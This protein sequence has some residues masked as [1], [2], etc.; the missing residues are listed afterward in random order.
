MMPSRIISAD[1]HMIEPPDLWTTR[2]DKKLRD[3]APHVEVSEKGSYFVAPGLKPSPVSLGFG[4]GRSGQELKEHFKKGYET[5]PAGGWD[6]VE[7]IKDQDIDGVIAEV[8]YTTYGM[9]LFSLPDPELQLA[10]FRAYNDWLAEFCAHNPR[11]FSGIGLISL[12][13]I[14]EGVKELERCAQI[15]LRGAQ[16]WGAPPADRPYWMRVWDPL[17]SAGQELAMPLSLH[18]GTGKRDRKA[19]KAPTADPQTGN[20]GPFMTGNYVNMVHELQRS[21]TDIIFGGVLER[22]PRLTL[23]SAENDSGWV[24]HYMYRMDHAFE[25][26]NAMSD[27]PLPQKPS[28]YIRRQMMATFQDDPIGPMTHEF[29]GADNYMWASDFPHTDCTWPYSRKVIERDFAKLPDAVTHKIV[30]ENVAR[31]YHMEV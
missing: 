12:E 18:I 1:S 3:Q 20:R 2:L 24:P 16:V 7:R 5:A 11:R 17:W 21:F 6:P 15:G 29:F 13:D 4:A 9:P 25:K 26:F 23:I 19:V 27:E 14:G 22:F 10:C 31:V 30:F 28:F 8:L